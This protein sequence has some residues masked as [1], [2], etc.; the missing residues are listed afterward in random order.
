[1]NIVILGESP[2]TPSS[3]GKVTM[4]LAT[5]LAELGY[6]VSVVVYS[7]ATLS[8]PLSFA[9]RLSPCEV[10][11]KGFEDLYPCT[12]IHVY[13]WGKLYPLSELDAVRKSD[14]LLVYGYPYVEL[15]LNDIAYKMFT[16]SGKPSIVYAL[17]EGAEIDPKE[18]MCVLAHS[19]VVAPTNHVRNMYINGLVSSLGVKRGDLE[20]YFFVLP[21]P[22]NTSVF[23]D[24]AVKKVSET[25]DLPPNPLHH[26]VVVGM[27]AKN[28]VRKDYAALVEAVVRARMETG[29][30]IAAGLYWIDSIS[31][32]YWNID[33]ITRKISR[34]FG[35]GES[36]LLDLI[37]V[38]PHRFRTC[39]I[40]DHMLAYVYSKAMHLHMFLTRGEAYGLPPVE[41]SLLGVPTVTTDIPPQREIFGNRIRYVAA[42][43]FDA[44]SFSLYRPDPADAAKAIL[45]FLE[46]K[47]PTPDPVALA[48]VHDYKA[49][50]RKL[51][52]I[53][54]FA[55]R[56]PKP[57]STKAYKSL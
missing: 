6:R 3:M 55:S 21:H 13:P 31:G 41:S 9:T 10:A 19:V 25:R 18:S 37:V 12:E 5:G 17:H 33:G 8:T 51:S 11:D 7:S 47:I 14:A 24:K 16:S 36:E 43:P 45:E 44:D 20:P 53:I 29:R 39:G 35:V 4:Y 2:L 27:V 34:R 48:E 26:D 56:T 38:L 50:A 1:M 22:L 57:L 46:G 52:N 49:V 32:N 28:H 40:P 23:T 15:D 54:E 42:H 30:E